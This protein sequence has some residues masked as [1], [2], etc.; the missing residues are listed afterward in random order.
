MSVCLSDCITVPLSMFISFPHCYTLSI[1]YTSVFNLFSVAEP[2]AAML[3]AHGT[4]VFWG[5]DEAWKAEIRG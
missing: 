4:H 3:I 1:I 2:H 5:T